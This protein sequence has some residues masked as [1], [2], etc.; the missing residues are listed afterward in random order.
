MPANSRAA[1]ATLLPKVNVTTAQRE[2]LRRRV[3]TAVTALAA[4]VA[5]LVA[6][7]VSVLLGFLA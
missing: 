2:M 7:V 4:F 5:V 6:S 3:A 1:D